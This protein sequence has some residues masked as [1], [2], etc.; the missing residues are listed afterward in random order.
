MIDGYKQI[1]RLSMSVRQTEEMVRRM[2]NTDNKG[3]KTRIE[4]ILSPRID[5]MERSLSKIIHGRVRIS[6]SQVE[7]KIALNF[8]GDL[9]V[10]NEKLDKIYEMIKKIFS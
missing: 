6:Q 10:T 7:A 2:Q 3:P 1:L 5:E 4:K 8:R 9:S